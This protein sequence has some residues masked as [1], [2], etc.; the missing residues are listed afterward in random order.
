MK[1]GDLISI[2]KIKLDWEDITDMYGLIIEVNKDYYKVDE[3]YYMR[4]PARLRSLFADSLT[5][6]WENGKIT[7]EPVSYVEIIEYESR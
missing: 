4:R 3:N 6:L 2:N 7:S 1:V 5:I